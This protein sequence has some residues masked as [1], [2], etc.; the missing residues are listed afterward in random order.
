MDVFDIYIEENEYFGLVPAEQDIEVSL[1]DAVALVAGEHSED[2]LV[3]EV[4]Y[5][6]VV[7]ED[8]LEGYPQEEL[9][10][11]IVEE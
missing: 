5:R 4:L 1:E 8:E 2:L 10:Y 9:E 3:V 7:E 6:E 11:L